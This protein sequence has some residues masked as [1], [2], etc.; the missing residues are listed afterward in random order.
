MKRGIYILC[1]FVVIVLTLSMVSAW[2]FWD[3]ITGKALTQTTTL[4]ITVTAGSA[5]VIVAVYNETATNLISGTTEGPALSYVIVVFRVNDPDGLANINNGSATINF[6]KTGEATRQNS[7]CAFVVG[8]STATQA[9]YSCNVTMWW[10][11]GPGTWGINAY[12]ADL[13]SNIGYNSTVKNLT[14]GSTNGLLANRSSITWPSISPGAANTEASQ[15]MGI[16]NTGNEAKSFYVNG[17]DLR[18]DV[19]PAYA[20]GATNFS[21]DDAAGCGGT[22]VTNRTS[23][24]MTAVTVIPRGNYTWNNATGQ[25]NIYFCLE[26]SNSNLIAQPYSTAPAGSGAWIVQLGT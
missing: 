18:G 4:N 17:S 3:K 13:S 19:N 22:F 26:T 25:A 11:D 20:L 6:S 5:P 23:I 8:Q 12:I 21:V 14:I 9:N 10:Y 15:F 7:S 16:N 1:F 24:N 2:D